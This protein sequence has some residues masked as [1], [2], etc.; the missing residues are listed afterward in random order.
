MRYDDDVNKLP[1]IYIIGVLRKREE[2][3]V[4]YMHVLNFQTNIQYFNYNILEFNF[5]LKKKRK[6]NFDVCDIAAQ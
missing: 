2:P 5:I 1:T 6:Y 4:Q 3:C